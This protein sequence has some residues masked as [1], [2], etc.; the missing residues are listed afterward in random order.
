MDPEIVALARRMFEKYRTRLYA[1]GKFHPLSF[2]EAVVEARRAWVAAAIVARPDLVEGIAV[3]PGDWL[4]GVLP[5][6]DINGDAAQEAEVDQALAEEHDRIR[7]GEGV[8]ER[9]AQSELL[10]AETDGPGGDGPMGSNDVQRR[11]RRARRLA[12]Y[13]AAAAYLGV[14]ESC[15]RHWVSSG[16]VGV[17]HIKLGRAVIFDL[18]EVDRFVQASSIGGRR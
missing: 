5:V 2:D 18:D 13:R 17:P 3:P 12:R 14:S 7:A 16:R 6:Y 9:R 10:Y 8:E 4:A 15:L 11:Q 1:E